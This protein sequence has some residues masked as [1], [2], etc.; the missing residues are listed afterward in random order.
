MKTVAAGRSSQKTFYQFNE[1][2]FIEI[3]K[4]LNVKVI[5]YNV[6][7]VIDIGNYTSSFTVHVI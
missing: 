3:N 1:N 4:R 6:K 7:K 2:I 5:F